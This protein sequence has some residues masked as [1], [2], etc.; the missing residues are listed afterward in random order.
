MKI[1]NIITVAAVAV[2]AV[3]SISAVSM[4]AKI[5]EQQEVIDYLGDVATEASVSYEAFEHQQAQNDELWG[6][7]YNLIDIICDNESENWRPMCE[8]RS[9]SL[10]VDE[11]M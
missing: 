10:V 4:S 1:N 11:E 3:A 6:S 8:D 5:K 7:V 9:W 2:A